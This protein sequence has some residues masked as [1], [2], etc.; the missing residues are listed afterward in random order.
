M[1]IIFMGTP[2]FA[3]IILETLYKSEHEIIAVMTQPDKP[4]GRGYAVQASEVKIY[5]EENKLPVYQPNTLR[6]DDFENLLRELSPDVIVVAAYGKLLPVNVLEFP[7]Y[8]CI[9]VHG[10]I[11]P[12]YRGAAPIQ[13]AIMNG[14]TV[15]GV[16]I[17]QMAEGLDT[18]DMFLKEEFAILPD[19]NFETVHDKMAL[20]G[21]K[22]LLET[23][24]L[25]EKGAIT[26]IKQNDAEATHA[27]KIEKSECA[28]NFDISAQNVHNMIRG[29]SPFPLAYGVLNGKKVKFIS[30]KYNKKSYDVQ[31]GTV[32]ALDNGVIT[33][34]CAEGS[35]E[36]DSVLPEGKNRMKSADFI[37]GR[38]VSVGDRFTEV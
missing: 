27:E 16:T 32:V 11:L 22:A 21:C 35:V 19:D 4:K 33:I 10:S 28:V 14:E 20:A 9:N 29:L 30:S 15:T 37:N 38:K 34:A 24:S 8:G 13:R 2:E 3:K 5:A 7:K 25:V 26:P 23:L 12:K 6:G 36:I 17:M 31:C 1:R 18:G